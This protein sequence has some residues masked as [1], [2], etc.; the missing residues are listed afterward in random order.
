MIILRPAGEVDPLGNRLALN[1]PNDAAAGD[2]L[3]VWYERGKTT[4]GDDSNDSGGIQ[5][6]P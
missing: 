3:A 5:G 1:M 6:S 2:S 4:R